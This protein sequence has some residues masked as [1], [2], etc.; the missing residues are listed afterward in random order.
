MASACENVLF[1]TESTQE[2]D[3][4]RQRAAGI[5]LQF[6]DRETNNHH[7]STESQVAFQ[8]AKARSLELL[9]RRQEALNEYAQLDRQKPEDVRVIL[10]IARI[11]SDDR[12]SERTLTRS[13]DY[14]QRAIDLLPRGSESWRT[15]MENLLRVLRKLG[16]D[17]TVRKTLELLRLTEEKER[18]PETF[19]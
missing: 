13:L 11:L 4:R 16:R 9:G 12:S 3:E 10:G 1:S 5:C 6:I 19:E 15:A 14:W 8:L 18:Q 17:E 7:L 2:G